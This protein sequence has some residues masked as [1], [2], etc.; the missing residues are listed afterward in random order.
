LRKVSTVSDQMLFGSENKKK[1]KKRKEGR[2]VQMIV[3]HYSTS[4]ATFLKGALLLGAGI[5]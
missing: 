1:K 5:S 4:S 3:A 2:S